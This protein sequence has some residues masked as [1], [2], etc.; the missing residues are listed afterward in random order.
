M[1]RLWAQTATNNQGGYRAISVVVLPRVLEQDG[2]KDEAGAST[3][4]QLWCEEGVLGKTGATF[5]GRLRRRI[6]A[7]KR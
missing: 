2:E 4:Q 5:L 7:F 1:W 6:V 3:L